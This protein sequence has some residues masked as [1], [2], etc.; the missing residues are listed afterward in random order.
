M[1]SLVYMSESLSVIFVVFL[2]AQTCIEDWCV[3]LC[4]ALPGQPLAY[5]VIAIYV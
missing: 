3:Q 2:V 5:T 4:H 1:L